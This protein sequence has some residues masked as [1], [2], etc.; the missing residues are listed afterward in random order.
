MQ[1]FGQSLRQ[2]CIFDV[3]TIESRVKEWKK[4]K[5][6]EKGF[7]SL[8]SLRSLRAS[9]CQLFKIHKARGECQE[10]TKIN[11]VSLSNWC[12]ATK[13]AL[14]MLVTWKKARRFS[15]KTRRFIAISLSSFFPLSEVSNHLFAV[16]LL[17]SIRKYLYFRSLCF[18]PIQKLYRK[19]LKRIFERKKRK[20]GKVSELFYYILTRFFVF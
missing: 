18:L 1:S 12:V 16:L 14:S 10:R 8:C 2:E 15:S 3:S 4:E 19:T 17:R 13:K 7:V 20:F 6:R 11:V 5:K 9:M